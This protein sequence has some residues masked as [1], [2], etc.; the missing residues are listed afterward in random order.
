MDLDERIKLFEEILEQDPSSKLFFQLAKLYLEKDKIDKS[1]STLKMGLSKH[2]EHMEARLLLIDLLTK[3][4]M[5]NEANLHIEKIHSILTKYTSFWKNWA[6]LLSKNGNYDLAL[7]IFVLSI[8]FKNGNL[9]SISKSLY[10]YLKGHDLLTSIKETPL[11][12]KSKYEKKKQKI[13]EGE[14]KSQAETKDQTNE[15]IEFKT[16]TMADILMAQGDYKGAIN[17]YRELLEKETDE[18]KLI[19]LKKCIKEAEQ[20][21]SAAPGARPI[22]PKHRA[23]KRKLLTTLKKLATRLEARAI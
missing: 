18:T 14:E 20:K 2:P 10:R 12:E 19:E 9:P 15:E 22:E 8:V 6:E 21:L 4:N 11:E 17:I 16:K 13:E 1:I 7:I 23:N 5:E 3:N